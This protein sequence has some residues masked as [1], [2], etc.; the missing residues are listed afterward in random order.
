MQLDDETT[1]VQLREILKKKGYTLSLST[2]LRCRKRLGWSFR[3]SSYCQM[4]RDENKVKR[5]NWAKDHLNDDFKDVIWSDET[6]V[7]MESHRRF[8]CR[9]KSQK[10]RYKPQYV[11]RSNIN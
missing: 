1:A 5:L 10:P 6:T 2:I 8:C 11:I 7:Q 3:G 4:I 9:K